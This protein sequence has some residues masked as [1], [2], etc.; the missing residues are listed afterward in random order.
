MRLRLLGYDVHASIA[1]L[2][3]I[4]AVLF[5][6][7]MFAAILVRFVGD[8]AVIEE[9][10]GDIWPRPSAFTPRGSAPAHLVWRCESSRLCWPP[11]RRQPSFSF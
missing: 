1:V 6:L 3:A 4:E 5:F 7:S 2:A 11:P 8:L 10:I 9:Q